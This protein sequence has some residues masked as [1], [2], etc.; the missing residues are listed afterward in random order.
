MRVKVKIY[1][2]FVKFHFIYLFLSVARWGY[3][4]W[5]SQQGDVYR[6]IGPILKISNNRDSSK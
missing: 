2:A 4:V 3:G 5:I 1:G 6:D